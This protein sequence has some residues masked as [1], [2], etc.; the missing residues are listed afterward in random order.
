MKPIHQQLRDIRRDQDITQQQAADQIGI[1]LWTVNQWD[2]G[3]YSPRLYPY[4]RY[5][6]I[7]HHQFVITNRGAILTPLTSALPD[8]AQIRRLR[9]RTRDLAQRLH[10]RNHTITMFERRLAD[11]SNPALAD[12][13]TYLRGFEHDLQIIPLANGEG[14][15]H[16]TGEEMERAS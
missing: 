3:R 8:I 5:A 15:R 6:T 14:W 13:H 12:V 7:L 1:T 4:I 10:V 2:C 11:G 16:V 9:I